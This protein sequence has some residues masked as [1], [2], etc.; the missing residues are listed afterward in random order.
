MHNTLYMLLL[1]LTAALVFTHNFKFFLYINQF[2]LTTTTML[3]VPQKLQ[4]SS[5]MA[6]LYH[7]TAARL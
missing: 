1:G 2:T 7:I 6:V 5:L 3:N 4:M